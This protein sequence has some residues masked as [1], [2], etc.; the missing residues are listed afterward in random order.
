ML[1]PGGRIAAAQGPMAEEKAGGAEPGAAPEGSDEILDL[2]DAA[3]SPP[4]DA[5]APADGAPAPPPLPQAAGDPAT[6]D[7]AGGNGAPK[8]GAGIETI[9]DLSETPAGEGDAPVLEEAAVGAPAVGPEAPKKKFKV[10]APPPPP[11]KKPITFWIGVLAPF[12]LFCG[13]LF[14]M[15][16]NEDKVVAFWGWFGIGKGARKGPDGPLVNDPREPIRKIRDE[17]R[18]LA[19][20]A[21]EKGHVTALY[22]QAEAKV[23]EAIAECEKWKKHPQYATNDGAQRALEREN[24][25]SRNILKWI[26]GLRPLISPERLK[27]L[28]AQWKKEKPPK[29][30]TDLLAAPAVDAAK[31]TGLALELDQVIGEASAL[32]ANPE[33]VDW[34]KAK[35][36]VERARELARQIQDACSSL[37]FSPPPPAE[38]GEQPV[39]EE[40]APKPDDAAP[41]GGDGG[42]DPA[43]GEKP[44]APE[45]EGKP[46][47]TG[48]GHPRAP[49]PA[50]PIPRDAI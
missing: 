40:E 17:A 25:E 1:A 34:E 46:E 10:S 45:G 20:E 29:P 49:A 35:A 30:A 37:R 11:P 38:D 15:S 27:E 23:N 22:D 18:R 12:V 31:V 48:A 50:G 13:G 4:A 41:E 32:L 28:E 21:K 3:A 39:P 43:P 2:E 8:D 5:A 16:R 47:G 26:R 44:A 33:H 14:W 19:L 42:A 36:A 24:V 7:G 9:E 6:G